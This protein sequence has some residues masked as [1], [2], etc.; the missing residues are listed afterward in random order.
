MIGACI[1]SF[2]FGC[3]L[4][5]IAMT[6]LIKRSLFAIDQSICA[7]IDQQRILDQLA[8]FVELHSTIKQLC[9]ISVGNSH[10]ID[11][12]HFNSHLIYFSLISDFSDIFEG[13]ITILFIWSL[14]SICGAML[15]IQMQLVPYI[16]NGLLISSSLHFHKI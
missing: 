10:T 16:H 14:V 12:Q 7:K 11:I 9:T 15:M 1:I 3:Y 8:E 2:A 5:G 13:F 4:L 6:K